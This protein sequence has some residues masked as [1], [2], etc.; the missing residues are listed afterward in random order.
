SEVTLK[1]ILDGIILLSQNYK[2]KIWLE[3]MVLRNIND[4]LNAAFDF[5][6]ALLQDNKIYDRIEKIHLNTPVRPSGFQEVFTPSI[7]SIQALKDILGVKAQTINQISED[8]FISK[9]HEKN[10]KLEERIIELAKRRP[11]AAKEISIALGVNINEI[12][13]CLRL[14]LKND[15]IKYKLYRNNRYYYL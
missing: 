7:E 2:G 9:Y 3:I 10:E 6:K 13:K 15:K 11:A 12:I 8:V 14:L 5:K 1:S 4:G